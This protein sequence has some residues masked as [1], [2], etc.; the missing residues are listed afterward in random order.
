MLAAAFGFVVRFGSNVPFWDDWETV[1]A[2]AGE[3]N[4]DAQWFWAAHNGHRIPF[5]RLFLLALYKLTGCDFRSG[6]YFNAAILGIVAFAM[7]IVAKKQ[8]G[9]ELSYADA[10]FPVVLLGWGHYEN[11]LWTWQVTQVIPV[12]VVCFLLCI[13]VQNGTRLVGRTGIVAGLLVVTLPLSGVPGLM[14]VPAMAL[15]LVI[16]G[17]QSGR[18]YGL[19]LWGLALAS[20]ALAAFYFVDYPLSSSLRL[21]EPLTLSTLKHTAKGSFSTALQFLT[22]SFGPAA[23]LSW[24]YSGKA[25]LGLL[26]ATSILLLLRLWRSIGLLLFLTGVGCLALSVGFGRRGISARYFLIAAPVLGL[27][28]Y[29]WGKSRVSHLVQTGL[30][31][32]AIVALPFNFREGLRY[33]RDYH[34]SMEAFRLDLLAGKS[35]AELVAHHAAALS[36]CALSAPTRGIPLDEG[37]E[38]AP[39]STFPGPWVECVSYHDWLVPFIWDMRRGG[40]GYFRLL[41]DEYPA[42]K[43]VRLSD[44]PGTLLSGGAPRDTNVVF[45]LQ[46]PKFVYGIRVAYGGHVQPG[47]VN[48]G[49]CLQVLWK[50]RDQKTFVKSQRYLHFWRPDERVH[51]IW[52]FDTI[53]SL[54]VNFDNQPHVLDLIDVEFLNPIF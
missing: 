33:A 43:D 13:I 46:R 53:D 1:P 26:I 50:K 45:A 12:A 3:Q 14:Y 49:P 8:R 23:E 35:D 7:I 22:R 5:P 39:S 21:T 44:V 41:R 28:Y 2:L 19:L 32:T 18:R 20:V 11:L 36:P 24:R 25:M 37:G 31:I 48:Q 38:T 17:L 27:I 34:R 54:A 30:F 40:I 42:S 4:I 6:M 16:G 52:I 51:T 15:W 29:A 10:F 47:S 9:G